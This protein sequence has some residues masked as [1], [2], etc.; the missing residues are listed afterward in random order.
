M[1]TAEFS[2][3]L[4]PAAQALKLVFDL[5]TAGQPKGSIRCPKC[6][7]TLHYTAQEPHRSSGR[8]SA[9]GCLRWSVI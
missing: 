5:A 9:G 8:C 2:A 4:S 7:S 3:Q 6:G 1:T